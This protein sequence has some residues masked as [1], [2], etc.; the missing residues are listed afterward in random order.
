VLK[1]DE[2]RW[3]GAMVWPTYSE[4]S[5]IFGDLFLRRRRLPVGKNFDDLFFFFF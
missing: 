5:T 3:G 1:V 4:G 2:E